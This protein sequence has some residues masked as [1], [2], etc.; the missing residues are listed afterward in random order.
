[1]CVC[2]QFFNADE[3]R[4]Y[5]YQTT[6]IPVREWTRLFTHL[7]LD[8]QWTGFIIVI[9]VVRGKQGMKGCPD[10]CST[11]LPTVHSS[12]PAFLRTLSLTQSFRATVLP[13]IWGLWHRIDAL[14]PPGVGVRTRDVERGVDLRSLFD[15]MGNVDE[16]HVVGVVEED[17]AWM[18]EAIQGA[19]QES[20]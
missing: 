6:T 15:S 8:T 19:P 20:W 3:N 10:N 11:S 1:M 18:L 2:L 9:L 5:F 7:A 12:L 14:A 4:T 17:L 13:L 16:G